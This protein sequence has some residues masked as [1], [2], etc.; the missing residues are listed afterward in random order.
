MLGSDIPRD[1][2]HAI[3]NTYIV[4]FSL[5][6]F[7]C[8][9]SLFP[10][11]CRFFIEQTVLLAIF[12]VL[13]QFPRDRVRAAR[14][15]PVS[16]KQKTPT[17]GVFD[18]DSAA[19]KPEGTPPVATPGYP[20]DKVVSHGHA[21]PRA[22]NA[23][24]GS[25]LGDDDQRRTNA[26]ASPLH[27]DMN[28]QNTAAPD[29]PLNMEG[30]ETRPP[31]HPG[32]Y[33][34]TIARPESRKGLGAWSTRDHENA[35]VP[36]S[37]VGSLEVSSGGHPALGG[38]TAHK[39]VA[40]GQQQLAPDIVLGDEHNLS[41]NSGAA[42][43]DSA[44]DAAA[45]GVGSVPE[46]AFSRAS[47]GGDI[48]SESE[49]GVVASVTTTDHSPVQTVQ[50]LTG[51]HNSRHGN[52]QT[53]EH[54][55]GVD[56]SNLHGLA[57]PHA[58]GAES[59]RSGR[60]HAAHTTRRSGG[61]FAEEQHHRFE[62]VG[63][64][65]KSRTDQSGGDGVPSHLDDNRRQRPRQS[66]SYGRAQ[67]L[68]RQSAA[69]ENNNEVPETGE[70]H[71][72]DQGF[73]RRESSRGIRRHDDGHGQQHRGVASGTG[74]PGDP[75]NRGVYTEVLKTGQTEGAHQRPGAIAGSCVGETR[76]NRRPRKTSAAAG[77]TVG[78]GHRKPVRPVVEVPPLAVHPRVAS[79]GIAGTAPGGDGT[80]HVYNIDAIEGNGEGTARG[81]RAFVPAATREV[82]EDVRRSIAGRSKVA[83]ATL[84]IGGSL[85]HTKPA[86]MVVG[87]PAT[88]ATGRMPKGG[89]GAT[90]DERGQ[91]IAA[92]ISAGAR[93]VSVNPS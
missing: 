2:I 78:E 86:S 3:R 18:G 28:N 50:G 60:Q 8:W 33:D 53:A 9:F 59:P 26:A 49:G 82:D 15:L 92:L 51:R 69:T 12:A 35:D 16:D 76:A 66:E 4:V 89:E 83:A 21:L 34:T 58:E 7:R 19:L 29:D 91:D 42:R 65:V 62:A 75:S 68:R 13:S 23:T 79:T 61:N 24:G 10:L 5:L 48:G 37:D 27:A 81:V 54:G 74:K 80:I 64:G 20:A 43:P 63:V 41:Q 6:L 45:K 90:A 71:Q 25:A 32:A 52:A 31:A 39:N 88:R 93:E 84:S 73:P 40:D 30:T 46:L 67:V 44:G 14:P 72:R 85:P 56:A 47:F 87:E 38:L 17:E 22:S 55:A 11:H 36:S 57:P 70:G 1:C 77:G